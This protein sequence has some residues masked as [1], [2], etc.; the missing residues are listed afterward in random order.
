MV[1]GLRSALIDIQV[2]R[3]EPHARTVAFEP[4]PRSVAVRTLRRPRTR[5]V[6][7]ERL[8]R[9]H[10]E[11]PGGHDHGPPSFARVSGGFPALQTVLLGRLAVTGGACPD[12]GF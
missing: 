2:R 11:Y 7:P 6:P 1:A 12:D 3:C 8:G 9:N 5:A 10:R 4:R